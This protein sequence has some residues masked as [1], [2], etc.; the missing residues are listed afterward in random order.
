MW[1][2]TTPAMLFGLAMLALPIALHLRGRSVRGVLVFPTIEL[3]HLC[4][5]RHTTGRR[6]RKWLLLVVRCLAL[7][8]WVL[9]FARPVLREAA[10]QSDLN[11]HT[12]WV[13]DLS[14]S[15]R[16]VVDGVVVHDR[17]S[18]LLDRELA[19]SGE[20]TGH[21]AVL[22]GVALR[23]VTDGWVDA[24]TLR[25]LVGDAQPVDAPVDLDAAMVMAERLLGPQST[26]AAGRIVLV[27]DGQAHDFPKFFGPKTGVSVRVI[28]L[29][30]DALIPD[31]ALHNLQIW[32]GQAT[33]ELTHTGDQSRVV[34]LACELEGK[35]LGTQ[36]VTLAPGQSRGVSFALG[37]LIDAA[38]EAVVSVRLVNNT[39]ALATDDVCSAV[40][41]SAERP[42]VMIVT[43]GD[44]M[45]SDTPA[46]ALGRALAPFGDA[47]DPVE[48]RVARA[49]APE[50]WP[51]CDVAIVTKTGGLSSSALSVMRERMAGGVGLIFIEDD[52][53]AADDLQAITGLQS[54]PGGEAARWDESNA[55]WSDAVLEAFTGL[56]RRTLLD[57]VTQPGWSPMRGQ[58]VEA[59][60]AW[61][62]GT[63][64]VWRK[65]GRAGNA[66]ASGVMGISFD[67]LFDAGAGAF[68]D[69]PSFVGL[70]HAMVGSLVTRHR[71]RNVTVGQP[72]VFRIEGRSASGVAT[73]HGPGVRLITTR[74]VTD[75]SG[76]TVQSD[77]TPISGVYT[78][79]LEGRT[80]AV[81]CAQPDVGEC[82]LTRV[83]DE[84]IRAVEGSG[85]HDAGTRDTGGAS[86]DT[87]TGDGAYHN[88]LEVWPWSAGLVGVILTAEVLLAGGGRRGGGA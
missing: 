9:T 74:G 71:G 62:D 26:G 41:E 44:A 2:L 63:P 80:S 58:S 19:Q 77:A 88:V 76:L 37:S 21:R 59:I 43:A 16:A 70:M 50:S 78:L 36:K 5:D 39:D 54:A 56:S 48:V 34:E 85:H 32:A 29:N 30:D 64:A 61:P 47:R 83:R 82:D 46:G 17:L 35:T 86:A 79:R 67:P 10:S 65:I 31:T 7:G 13:L 81:G 23:E 87:H 38:N 55:S 60:L 42:R 15:T 18:A 33:V 1:I 6:V 11:N 14:G 8:L 12:V 3:L 27:T 51:T 40:I 84:A 25:V 24:R 72:M 52:K 57:A 49:D 28:G 45:M 68:A 69:S 20:T 4:M 73:L 75:A 66:G 53:A 22:A